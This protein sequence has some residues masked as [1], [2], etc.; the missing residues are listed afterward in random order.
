M[1]TPNL[2]PSVP[3]DGNLLVLWVPAI[4]DMNAPKMSEASAPSAVDIT[5]YLV[6]SKV[7]VTKDQ[8]SITDR[9][10][11]MTTGRQ[12]PGAASLSSDD[13]VYVYDPQAPEGDPMNKAADVL[14]EQEVGFFLIRRGM[15]YTTALA[16]GQFVEVRHDQLGVRWD[17]SSATEDFSKYTQKIFNKDYVE[18]VAL[19]A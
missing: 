18:K 8:S 6:D 2:P 16:A 10:M 13:I 17:S 15:P 11:C 12:V 4:A 19:G 1:A 14:A 9:R 7:G 5:C 3:V